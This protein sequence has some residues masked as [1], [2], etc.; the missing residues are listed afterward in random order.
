MSLKLNERYPGRF[1][2]PS[3]DYPDG[4]FKNRTAPAAKDGSYL[5]QDWANDREGFFQSL[6]AAAGI[7]ANGVV[8]KVG[9]SQFFDAIQKLK[10]SQSGTAFPTTGPSTALVLTP[11]PAITAYAAGQRFRV[12]FNRASTGADTINISGVGPKSL[13]Q[14]DAS[15]A[16]V[17]AV[18]SIDQLTDVEYDGTDA[19]ILDQ[20]PISMSLFAPINSPM[21]TGTPGTNSTPPLHDNGARLA[22]TNFVYQELLSLSLSVVGSARNLKMSVPTASAS[23]TLTAD[24]IIVANSLGGAQL[25]LS[26]F[27]K[28]I[29]LATVGAGGMDTGTA[30]VSGFVAIYAIYNPTTQTSA[31]LAR[32]ATSAAAPSVYGGANMPV[33]YNASALVSAWGTNA[34]GQLK[35]GYQ[36]DRTISAVAISVLNTT[37]ASSS[38]TA[39]NVSAAIPLNATSAFGTAG[40]NS[41]AGALNMSIAA[42]N[43]GV[44][45]GLQQITASAVTNISSNFNVLTPTA[46]RIYYTFT[47]TG[48]SAVANI[49]IGGYTI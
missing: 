23:A 47:A 13:K 25:K 28:T 29:N 32:N 14:Y 41:N 46:Q 44:G 20:L 15:G 27:N 26:A 22:N 24:E 19:V 33:G 2:N 18:F 35:V 36:F 30:P 5:E 12:K 16:K 38:F 10:Q 39:L 17:P 8:D 31:L 7:D 45:S 40:L 21:F 48:S 1:N 6:L 43:S 4:S 9:A 49:F 37:A 42:D 3:A 11:S 34:S